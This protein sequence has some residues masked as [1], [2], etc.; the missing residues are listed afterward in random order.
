MKLSNDE[1]AWLDE[2]RV[3]LDKEYPGLVEDIVIFRSDEGRFYLP[4]YSLNTVVIL[5]KGDRRTG[6]DVEFMGHYLAVLSE[7]FPFIWA[8]TQDEWKLHRRNETLPYKGDGLSV[9]S[10]QS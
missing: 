1:Q 9:W 3:T 2:Y 4:E 10:R 7:A 8:Y 5:K 6:K